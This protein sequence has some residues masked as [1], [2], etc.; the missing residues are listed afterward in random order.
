MVGW[1]CFL[2]F[3]FFYHIPLFVGGVV[4]IWGIVGIFRPGGVGFHGRTGWVLTIAVGDW[5]GWRPPD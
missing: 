4:A 1:L 2:Y 5:A 3:I